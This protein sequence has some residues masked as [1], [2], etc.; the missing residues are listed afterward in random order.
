MIVVIHIYIHWLN[1]PHVLVHMD[2]MEL[3]KNQ[4]VLFGVSLTLLIAH[5]FL[6]K[7]STVSVTEL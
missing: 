2:I 4:H 5:V 7:T 1:Y 6:S 3:G